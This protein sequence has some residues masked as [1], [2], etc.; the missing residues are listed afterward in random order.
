MLGLQ[1][2]SFGSSKG[3]VIPSGEKNIVVTTKGDVLTLPGQLI[4]G[5]TKV[6]PLKDGTYEIKFKPTLPNAEWKKTILTE[7]ELIAKYG[8]KAGKNFQAVA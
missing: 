2:L 7:E 4:G 3:Q 1:N 6:K 5:T 8:E